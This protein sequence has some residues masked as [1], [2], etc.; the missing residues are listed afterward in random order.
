MECSTTELRQHARESK[1]S[2]EE[3]PAGG[4]FLPQGPRWRKHAGPETPP[5]RAKIGFRRLPP[6][7]AAS[8]RAKPVPP[9]RCDDRARVGVIGYSARVQQHSR[10][11]LAMTD[12][13]DKAER[14]DA[15][16]KDSRRDRLK[17]ALRE[18]L[19]RRKSQARG[20][21]DPANASSESGDGSL[22]DASG[23]SRTDR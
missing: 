15:A 1:E 9:R 6:A 8:T 5:K 23:K 3:A 2:A 13:R 17:L 22:D 21:S 10:Q 18:N 20:R 12:E 16:A 7:W 14:Q 19:K 4:R 11:G